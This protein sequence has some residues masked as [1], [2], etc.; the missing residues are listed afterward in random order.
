MT[1][2]KY[3][4]ITMQHL[5]YAKNGEDK[6]LQF[7]YGIYLSFELEFRRMVF[8][9]S[10]RKRKPQLLQ[11][12]RVFEG[13]SGWN[14]YAEVKWSVRLP[15]FSFSSFQFE[16]DLVHSMNSLESY[17]SSILAQYCQSAWF[18]CCNMIYSHFTKETTK[19]R[20]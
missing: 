20:S 8:I 15:V 13:K 10:S 17:W 18:H 7:N 19:Y 16:V 1:S 12:S 5:D 6:N 2:N 14:N 4:C 9:I 3:Y 11:F